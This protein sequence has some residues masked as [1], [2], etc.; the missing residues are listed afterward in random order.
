[1]RIFALIWVAALLAACS[2]GVPSTSTPTGGALAATPVATPAETGGLFDGVPQGSAPLGF[3]RAGFENAPVSVLVYAAFDDPASVTFWRDAAPLLAARARA[4][5]IL[6]TYIPL[7]NEAVPNARGAARAALCA[8]EQS[9]FWAYAGR[10]YDAVSAEG[11]GGLTGERLIA[12]TDATGLDR[13]A[14]NLCMVGDRPDAALDET[15]RAAGQTSLFSAAPLILVNSAASL[16]DAASLDFTIDR[17]LSLFETQLDRALT[18]EATVAAQVTPQPVIT[19]Q[20]LMDDAI[21]PPITLDLPESWAVGY[22]TLLLE[23]LDGARGVPA[24]VYS[25]PVSGGNG[26]IVLLWG[27]PNVVAPNS[28]EAPL[29]IDLYLDGLRL[30]RLAVVEAGCNIGSDLKREYVVG[31]LAAVGTTFAAVDCPELPDTR[32]WFAGLRQ[33]G[34]NFVFFAFTDPIEAMDGAAAAELQAILDSAVFMPVPEPTATVE[35]GS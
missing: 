29:Q 18:P 13:E 8:G 7:F 25:G 15:Q 5:E 20:P 14:W 1:M 12:L 6:V 10:V 26:T 30:L 32:G 11:E 27:F 3:P 31:G 34:L 17:A 2:P 21:Q 24:A 33:Y 22:A 23:D 9:A 35:A 28:G 16:P 19:I 4:G